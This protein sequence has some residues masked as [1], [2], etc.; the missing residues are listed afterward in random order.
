MAHY[1][2]VLL[3]SGGN[4]I[5]SITEFESFSME[6][7]LNAPNTIPSLPIDGR[8]GPQVD[9]I[10]ELAS[11]IVVYRDDY[12]L[13]RGRIGYAQDS[14]G[15]NRHTVSLSAVDYRGILDR[16]IFW[17]DRA[18]TSTDQSN[19][20]WDFIQYTQGLTGGNLGITRG[21]GQ[22][23]GIN[24]DRDYE[25]G[26]NI[27]E[28]L[29]QLSEVINGFEYEISPNLEFN[30][31]YPERGQSTD[32]ILELGG[33]VDSATRTV[34]PQ[35]FANAVRGH[36]DETDG[37]T[38]VAERFAANLSTAPEGRYDANVWFPDVT[39]QNTTNDKT[40]FELQKRSQFLPSYSMT[41]KP[42][43]WHSPDD[44]WLGDTAL[45]VIRSGRL[46][47]VG[48]YRVQEAKI[49]LDSSDDEEIHFTAGA[50]TPTFDK[51]IRT[52]KTTLSE[53]E[54]R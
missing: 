3:D 52:F 5:Q 49:S 12:K 10:I 48:N 19:I 17:V 47:V 24:R 28:A 26:K 7:N 11:D 4:T 1:N 51:T 43:R 2:I 40:D 15:P 9:D 42:G 21:V 31:Y 29:K 34:S 38:P 37:V 16:R 39:R 14:I 32:F 18:Y 27:G 35:D 53:L 13:F 8:A 23:T 46:N 54:R 45:V 41:V 44:L 25:A 6:F 50:P 30:L 36:G 33:T 20:A 22:S